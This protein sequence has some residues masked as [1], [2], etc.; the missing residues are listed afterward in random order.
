MKQL[1]REK[2][3]SALSY[4]SQYAG[5]DGLSTG[6]D[7][8]KQSCLWYVTEKRGWQDLFRDDED[9]KKRRYAIAGMQSARGLMAGGSDSTPVTLFDG[10]VIPKELLASYNVNE[11][12]VMTTAKGDYQ[13]QKTLPIMVPEGCMF[14]FSGSLREGDG[15]STVYN[16]DDFSRVL[17]RSYEGMNYTNLRMIDDLQ[18]SVREKDRTIEGRDGTIREKN[19][20]IETINKQLADVQN[21]LAIAEGEKPSYV[22]EQSAK[23][24]TQ[25]VN[26]QEVATFRQ[27]GVASASSMS[28]TF[29]LRI[30]NITSNWRNIFHVTVKRYFGPDELA[31]DPEEDFYRKPAVFI[32]PNSKALHICHDTM[33]AT[34]NPFN[35]FDIPDMCFVGLVW[36]GRTLN[37]YINSDRVETFA[38][39]A[40]LKIAD[41]SA[42]LYISDRFYFGNGFSIRHLSFYNTAL[43]REK[44]LK[45]Y[46]VEQGLI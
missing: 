39:T 13:M 15:I 3:D 10:C 46:S 14:D 17:L 19:T 20:A 28:V 11:N 23:A 37:V 45:K 42:I 31:Y 30:D 36:N 33:T 34:N 12:C 8:S 32:I 35:V 18:G 22:Y 40:D 16:K 43:S 4:Q 9:G 44:I 2:F 24:W 5:S 6:I 26:D 41:P 1:Y 29:W 21:T 25:T 7:P 27:L 38:Y